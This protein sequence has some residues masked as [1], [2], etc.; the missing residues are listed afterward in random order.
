MVREGRTE[1]FLEAELGSYHEEGTLQESAGQEEPSKVSTHA[2]HSRCSS[3]CCL[4][5]PLLNSLLGGGE[6]NLVS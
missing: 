6:W 1:K 4:K 5:G 3:S 2:T